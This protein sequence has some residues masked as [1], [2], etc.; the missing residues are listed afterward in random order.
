MLLELTIDYKYGLIW[1]QLLK[2]YIRDTEIIVVGKHGNRFIQ[3]HKERGDYVKQESQAKEIIESKGTIT[4]DKTPSAA[5]SF[6]IYKIGNIVIW[7]QNV[8]FSTDTAA[9]TKIATIPE[10]YRPSQEIWITAF[11]QSDLEICLGVFAN[12]DVK[13]SGVSQTLPAN[14][15]MNF[16]GVWVVD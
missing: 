7:M 10:G 13:I 9:N 14:R 16:C 3:H 6:K 5:G 1:I 2:R 11:G 4:W 15:W 8:L 12:G